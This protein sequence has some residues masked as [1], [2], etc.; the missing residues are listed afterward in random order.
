MTCIDCGKPAKTDR[1]VGVAP[2]G[3]LVTDPVCWACASSIE[4]DLAVAVEQRGREIAREIE[5]GLWGG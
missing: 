2:D 1:P 4:A 5:K 3:K